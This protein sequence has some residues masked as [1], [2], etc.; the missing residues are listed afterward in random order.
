MLTNFCQDENLWNIV[1]KNVFPSVF[2][3]DRILNRIII[4]RSKKM[5]NEKLN[6]RDL[7]KR[8]KLIYFFILND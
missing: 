5:R 7:I 4:I 2:R 1:N 8:K 3:S 6:F